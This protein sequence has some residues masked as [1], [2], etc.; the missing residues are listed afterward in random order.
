M[1]N[2]PP[3][4]KPS[5]DEKVYLRHWMYDEVHYRDGPGTAKVLQRDHGASP[6][7]LATL[8][9]AA[10]PDPDDQATAGF[11]PPPEEP[12]VWP[13]SEAEFRN[14]LA[15][16]QSILTERH[17]GGPRRGEVTEADVPTAHAP[18]SNPRT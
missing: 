18:G 2:K 1:P 10:I 14:R 9:A 6:A 16:A 7:E 4:M 8:I 12:P 5:R 17:R 13:W 3:R 15:D 11:G